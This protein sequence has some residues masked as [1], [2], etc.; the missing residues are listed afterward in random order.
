MPAEVDPV[1]AENVIRGP[2]SGLSWNGLRRLLGRQHRGRFFAQPDTLL[3]WH[4]AMVRRKW[5]QP[6]RSGRPGIPVGPTAVILRLAREN[7]TW[8][9]RRIHGEL[10]WSGVVLAGSSV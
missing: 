3:R 4:R 6:H 1:G 7:R 8:G 9:Y 5:T 2:R 10:A